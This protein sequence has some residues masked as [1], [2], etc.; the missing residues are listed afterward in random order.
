MVLPSLRHGILVLLLT[1][2][3]AAAEPCGETSAPIIPISSIQGSSDISPL[4]GKTVTVEGIMT[5]DARGKGGF[6][7]FYL[8][9]A[10]HLTDSDP[11]TSE[12]L[13]VYTGRKQGRPEQRIRVRGTVKEH[14]GLTELTNIQD[15][16]VCGQGTMPAPLH[17][18]LPWPRDPESFENMRVVFDAP[19]TVIDTYNLARFGELALSNGDRVHPNESGSPI[20]SETDEL[21]LDDGQS[22]QNPHP[23]PWPPRGLSVGNTVRAGDTLQRVAGI[24]DY[25]FNSWRIQPDQP[26]EF[27]ASNPRKPAPERPAGDH[28]RIVTQNLHNMFNGDGQGNGFPTARGAHSADAFRRQQQRLVAALTAPNPDILALSELENDGYGA[29]SAAHS[30]ANA[31]GPAWRLV[32]TPE[33]DGE[34]AIRTAIL[35]RSDRVTPVGSPKRLTSGAF[36]NRGRPPLA[37]TFRR[38]GGQ[39]AVQV[40]AVHLKSKS[41][42][43]ASGADSDQGQ[44]CYTNRRVQEAKSVTDWLASSP[45]PDKLAGTLITGD[46]NS[47]AREAPV[48]EFEKGGYTSMLHHFHPCTDQHCPHYTYRYKGEKGSL[49]YALASTPLV[50]HMVDVRSWLINADEPRAL[51]YQGPAATSSARPW[52]SSDHNPL[53]ID[54]AL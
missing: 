1:P 45:T 38:L 42:R 9:Q 36:S 40:V 44:G 6:R 26:P 24:L 14:Y 47:Y 49:D 30:L 43:G 50:D 4:S 54:I 16:H 15:I 11:D 3:A 10:D 21:L 48:R 28:L 39:L 5:R 22:R 2:I 25:R 37:Q 33:E 29:D 17:L 7:G 53:I 32:T 46:L 34:D 20:A 52:R 27:I 51:G 8:Q 18:A 41:C 13:F 12:A 23:I 35:Y 31:L 19:L